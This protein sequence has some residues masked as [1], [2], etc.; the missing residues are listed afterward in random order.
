MPDSEMQEMLVN[1]FG[2]RGYPLRKYMRMMY[3][4][5]KFKNLSP[6]RLPEQL[7]FDA[8]DLAFLA[9]QRIT[10][11]DNDTDISV[12]DVSIRIM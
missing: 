2:T 10:S 11:V 9:I 3:W 12:F 5:P 7:P 1:I 6:W 8:F 4:M